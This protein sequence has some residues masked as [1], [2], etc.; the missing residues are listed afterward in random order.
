LSIGA[1][2]QPLI[3]PVAVSSRGVNAAASASAGLSKRPSWSVIAASASADGI[4]APQACHND[5]DKAQGRT[6]PYGQTPVLPPPI[7]A[8]PAASRA[9]AIRA[10]GG[11]PARTYALRPSTASELASAP[12]TTSHAGTRL[13]STT[14]YR[15]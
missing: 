3:G 8:T 10:V 11:P 12:S 15:P 7:S 5:R 13:P 2:S 6:A 9:R 4:C 1:G 14:W